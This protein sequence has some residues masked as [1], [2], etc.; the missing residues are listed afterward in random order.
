MPRP[1]YRR[2]TSV[3]RICPTPYALCSNP[4]AASYRDAWASLVRDNG[5][6]TWSIYTHDRHIPL[7]EGLTPYSPDHFGYLAG[8]LILSLQQPGG[9]SA[10][11][12]ASASGSSN[13][14]SGAGSPVLYYNDQFTRYRFNGYIDGWGYGK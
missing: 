6:S 8:S 7:P 1:R 9:S 12:S 2:F 4:L 3:P 5:K 14:V 10:A 11:G 13:T